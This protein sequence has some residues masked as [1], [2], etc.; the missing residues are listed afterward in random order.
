[1]KIAKPG[2]AVA[3][4]ALPAFERCLAAL[5]VCRTTDEA[6]NIRNRATAMAA[7]A[8]QAKDRRLEADSFEIR[9]RAERRLGEMLVEQKATIGLNTGTAGKGRPGLGGSA[10][11]PPKRDDRPTLAQA[12]IDKK[13]S[14]RA[15]RLATLSAAEFRLVMAEGRERIL[16]V[17]REHAPLDNLQGGTEW[18]TPE[19]WLKRVRAAMGGIDLDPATCEFAQRLVR[20]REWFNIER[21]GLAQPWH[22]RVFCNPP[23]S[24]GV[25]DRFVDKVLAE[26]RHYEQA[27]VLVDNRSDTAWFHRLAGIASALA[28]PKGRI[29]FYS[30]DPL[31]RAP[32][33]WGSAFAYVGNRRDA[34][35]AAFADSCLILNAA[36]A[37]ARLARAA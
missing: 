19:R 32:S 8:R 20:A 11:A 34:F 1:M 12:G 6:R 28:L 18:F 29:A 13:L 36:D 23:Y 24:R 4:V 35:A 37:P 15:Q 10:A 31:A 9:L 17:G 22:G 3:L 7:Y 33:I 16:A 25:I 5:A 2:R 27:I 30:E 21:D 14:M 26:R